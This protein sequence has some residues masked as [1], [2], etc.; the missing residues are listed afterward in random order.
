MFSDV[1][2]TY[3]DQVALVSMENQ[4]TYWYHVPDEGE[5]FYLVGGYELL[6]G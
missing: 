3:P 4:G 6:T 2:N 5:W 1:L